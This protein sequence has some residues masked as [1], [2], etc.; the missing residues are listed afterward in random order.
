[1]I[2]Q[3]AGHTAIA[4]AMLFLGRADVDLERLAA[5]KASERKRLAQPPA[6]GHGADR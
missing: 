2:A 4:D 5:E 1:M 3:Q 6:G